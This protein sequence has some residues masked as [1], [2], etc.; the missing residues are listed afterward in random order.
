MAR[1]FKGGF[2]IAVHVRTVYVRRVV[3]PEGVIKFPPAL[4]RKASVHAATFSHFRHIGPSS[5]WFGHGRG[6]ET[7]PCL[8]CLRRLSPEGGVP[9]SREETARCLGFLRRGGRLPTGPAWP[10]PVAPPMQRPV[11]QAVGAKLARRSLDLARARCMRGNAKRM[12]GKAKGL[13]DRNT[14]ITCDT[15]ER[16]LGLEENLRLSSLNGRKKVEPSGGTPNG[17]DR[18]AR[19]PQNERRTEEII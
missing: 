12:N 1:D 7:A 4:S 6:E 14:F 2:K 9:G 11:A 17:C 16:G 19:K 10:Q 8:G 13:S 18:E 3:E 15:G 5:G